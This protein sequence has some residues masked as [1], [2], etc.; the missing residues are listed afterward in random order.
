MRRK[1]VAMLT[2]TNAAGRFLSGMLER[3]DAPAES[4]VRILV[5]PKGLRMTIDQE[6]AGD[7][8]FEH[9]GR[10][11]LVLDPDG[12]SKLSERTLDVKPDGTRL[13]CIS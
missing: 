12:A 11:V 6:R 5:E 7:S 2:V 13:V 1:E 10:K 8:S 3:S 9:E 4:A